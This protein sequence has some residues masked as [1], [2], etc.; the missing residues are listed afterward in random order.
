MYFS[1]KN[2]VNTAIL[3]NFLSKI[4]KIKDIIFVVKYAPKF[5]SRCLLIRKT[6]HMHKFVHTP[7]C[8]FRVVVNGPVFTSRQA[9]RLRVNI[10]KAKALTPHTHSLS[11]SMW[12]VQENA[13]ISYTH[14]HPPPPLLNR[15]WPGR[16][17]GLDWLLK[18]QQHE[19]FELCFFHESI[20]PRP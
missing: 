2:I 5:S 17:R 19:I 1:T 8:Y 10:E 3:I 9:G 4:A 14:S 20:V 7:T 15:E 11:E 18:G 16:R 13:H 12:L 6:G